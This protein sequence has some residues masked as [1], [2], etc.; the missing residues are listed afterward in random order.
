MKVNCEKVKTWLKHRATIVPAAAGR[1][2]VF[3]RKRVVTEFK[4]SKGCIEWIAENVMDN[5]ALVY[6]L[7]FSK[8]V[9]LFIL[10]TQEQPV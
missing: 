9:K 10:D 6:R 1:R 7:L 2:D 4:M 8:F 5:I 3:E